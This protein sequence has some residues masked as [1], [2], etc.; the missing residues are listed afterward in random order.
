MSEQRPA[1]VNI[2]PGA[3]V[4]AQG[5][6][7]QVKQ[8]LH[9]DSVLARDVE[10]GKV[11]VLSIKDLSAINESS[12]PAPVNGHR[13]L[14][15]I[16][17]EKWELAQERFAVIRP[18]LEADQPTRELA[19]ELAEKADIHV[20]TFYAWLRCYRDAGHVS[21]LIPRD[22]G[23][24]PG[25]RRLNEAQE[26]IIERAIE[27]FYLKKQRY[28]PTDVAQEVK[29]MCQRAGIEPPH[30]NTVRNRIKAIPDSVKLRRRGRIDEARD[31]FSP[32]KDKF[33]GADF[34]LAVTQIDHTPAD[35]IVVDEEHRLPLG[36][37]TLTLQIDVKTRVVTG[38][39]ILLEAPSAVSVGMCVSN[40]M[41]PKDEYLEELG[42]EGE[43]PVWGCPAVLHADNAREFR[44]KMLRQACENYGID[45]QL[46][47]VKVPH[48]GG[49]IERLMGTAANELRKLPGATFSNPKQ[50]RG[51]KSEKEAAL[52]LRELEQQLVDF[53]VNVY[54]KRT[55]SELG[56]SPL[57]R[58][59]LDLLG[60][61]G[62][63]PPGLPSVPGDPERLKID[64]LPFDL[65]TVQRYGIVLDKVNYYHECLVPWINSIDPD[66]P[67]LKRKFVVR[68]DPRDISKI[69]FLDPESNLYYPVPYRD[70]SHP[71]I[72]IWELRTAREEARKAGGEVDEAAI[73][74]AVE[75]MRARSESA[76]AKT[77]QARRDRHRAKRAAKLALK[78][79][80]EPAARSQQPKRQPESATSDF[81]EDIYG[82][83]IQPF[84]SEVSP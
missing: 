52:T 66:Q 31:R 13:D 53:I 68:Y 78:S 36:R 67:K 5:R 64:F 83:D 72:S 10:T 38:I 44:G 63:P 49:H 74:D 54:H 42:V 80:G 18:Y 73:F 6:D 37:P 19:S 25:S 7:F 46:R 58:W 76:V 84:E 23:P 35:V 8:A 60:E 3:L 55:H 4:T 22:R 50:R 14:V 56:M 11:E 41:L 2:S 77:R 70:M 59:E 29:L 26:Q 71:A 79:S 61:D 32:I 20:T 16:D 82:E 57:R 69:W 51:Y 65:R 48:Y 12:E 17:K 47:P 75:R 24:R 1:F 27:Q 43:W 28:S 81:Q 30:G 39:A 40:S 34:P 45:L 9:L 33:P 15:E 62:G 21:G